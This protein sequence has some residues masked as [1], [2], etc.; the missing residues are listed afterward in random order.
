MSILLNALNKSNNEQESAEALD[1]LIEEPVKTGNESEQ[2]ADSDVADTDVTDSDVREASSFNM[3][4]VMFGFLSL[5]VIL[6]LV[7]VFLLLQQGD[8]PTAQ[9]TKQLSQDRLQTQSSP[10]NS[11]AEKVIAENH[12]SVNKSSG[13]KPEVS[14]TENP[15]SEKS[16]RTQPEHSASSKNE[17]S[18]S[19]SNDQYFESFKPEKQAVERI[20]KTETYNDNSQADMSGSKQH[21]NEQL[22]NQSSNVA[23]SS[24]T[25]SSGKSSTSSS[26][27]NPQINKAL[28]IKEFDQ[29]T[30]IEQL[31]VNEIT[32]DAH[33][34]SEEASQRFIFMNDALI[35]EGEKIINS[36]Y[37]ESI[38]P[39]GIVVNNGVLRVNIEKQ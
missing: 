20:T 38:E 7:I 35:Q 18:L 27:Q 10:L 17:E 1:E 24:A 32:L 37:L 23:N 15:V 26:S 39:D 29:L 9:I 36:W 5:I 19:A 25:E 30:E 34:Y 8:D 22:A 31:M 21:H 16:N 28:P 3:M 4:A 13:N 12:S 14:L 33:V 11:S 2:T 6:L